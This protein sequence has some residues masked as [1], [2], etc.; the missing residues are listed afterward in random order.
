MQ[1]LPDG[2]SPR[3]QHWQGA[4]AVAPTARSLGG[5]AGGHSGWYGGG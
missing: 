2:D 5:S 1:L 4:W 3:R